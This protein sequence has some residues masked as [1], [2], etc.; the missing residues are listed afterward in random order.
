MAHYDLYQSLGLD[1]AADSMQLRDILDEKI[2]ATS[3][4]DAAALD[5]RSTARAILGN[6]ELRARYDAHL[7]DPSAE[8]ITVHTLHQLAA[9]AP[10]APTAPPAAAAP[11]A[12]AGGEPTLVLGAV[13]PESA[14][15][16]GPADAPTAPSAAIPA[17][18]P[19]PTPAPAPP[20]GPGAPAPA[21]ASRGAGL[22]TKSLVIGLA[23]GAVLTLVSGA[24]AYGVMSLLSPEHKAQ[25]LVKDMLK[26][27]TE[28][29]L[30]DWV[31]KH[32]DPRTRDSVMSTLHLDRSQTFNGIDSLLKTS[33]PKVGT[34]TSF[35]G[36][37]QAVFGEGL[38]DDF[39][40][41]STGI[42]VDEFDQSQFVSILNDDNQV[43]A[44]VLVFNANKDPVI[45]D[46]VTR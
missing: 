9:Q 11:A 12:P 26:Q 37:Y 19:A 13:G 25:A 15:A 7:E 2:A 17:A 22:Q 44:V 4:D 1:R 33:H 6:P 45:L 21:K 29:D 32:T 10:A 5:E 42:R 27:D 46:L 23:T 36:K 16:P 34:A 14:P 18:P 40:S 43:K 28:Q 35:S 38:Y 24:G 8:P 31:L 41:K 30:R 39:P 3:P 20:Y